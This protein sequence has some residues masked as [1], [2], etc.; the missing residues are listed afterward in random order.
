MKKFLLSAMSL[1]LLATGA[2]AQTTSRD[3]NG[4]ANAGNMKNTVVFDNAAA[5]KA[6]PRKI[7]DNEVLAGYEGAGEPKGTAGYPGSDS[8]EGIAVGAQ[9][10]DISNYVGYTLVGLRFAVCGE[11]GAGAGIY[12]F[13][14]DNTSSN[15]SAVLTHGMPSTADYTISQ[16][17]GNQLDLQWNDIYFDEPHTI[18]AADEA[19]R[20]GLE[21]N[22]VSD[23]EAPNAYPIVIGTTPDSNSG[24]CF[25]GYGSFGPKGEGWYL[26]TNPNKAPFYTPC[27]QMI[28]QKPGS[29]AVEGINGAA[30]TAKQYFTADGKQLSAPQKGLNIV[31]MSDGTVRKVV[32]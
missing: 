20:Y 10:D 22:Q 18:T 4:Y 17:S 14:W 19:V 24:M 26:M 28:L 6:G 8:G 13:V 23:D 25:V 27:I 5:V 15:A 11:L 30:A 7:K 3:I 1:A 9:I 16:I 21:Y 29:T 31:K 12:A 32:R 2:S